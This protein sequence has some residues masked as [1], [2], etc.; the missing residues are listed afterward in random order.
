MF[1][2]LYK[3]HRHDNLIYVESNYD[4]LK[5][6]IK[7]LIDEFYIKNDYTPSV[8]Y[9]NKEDMKIVEK[10]DFFHSLKLHM[11]YSSDLYICG[12]PIKEGTPTRVEGDLEETEPL[13]FRLEM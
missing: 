2:K 7:N 1:T 12:L 4:K 3:T 9:L 6:K 13:L 10:F 5:S 8:V 11:F